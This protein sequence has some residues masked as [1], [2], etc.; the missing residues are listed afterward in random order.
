MYFCP[1]IF[2][3]FAVCTTSEAC[4]AAWSY[5]L[6]RMPRS[7]IAL[8]S[9]ADGAETVCA[10]APLARVAERTMRKKT[11]EP[12]LLRRKLF[13]PDGRESEY[14]PIVRLT[15]ENRPC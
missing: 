5:S 8:S 7:V 6:S 11:N 9:A 14:H 15:E 12:S 13:A 4:H 2:L 3:G 1:S 10:D